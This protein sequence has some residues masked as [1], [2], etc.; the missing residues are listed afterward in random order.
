MVNY[1]MI[2]L[3]KQIAQVAAVTVPFVWGLVYLFADEDRAAYLMKWVVNPVFGNPRR[4]CFCLGLLLLLLS[5]G[6]MALLLREY[7]F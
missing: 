2:E 5:V 6:I 1:S 4:W 7:I 3:F